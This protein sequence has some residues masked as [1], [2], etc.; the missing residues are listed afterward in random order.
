M[1]IFSKFKRT[2]V[3]DFQRRVQ[4]LYSWVLSFSFYW[5]WPLGI[6]LIK[7]QKIQ[8]KR[9]VSLPLYDRN[10]TG[11]FNWIFAFVWGNFYLLSYAD[12]DWE[13]CKLF[14]TNVEWRNWNPERVHGNPRA[15]NPFTHC[16]HHH[17]HQLLQKVMQKGKG[18][19]IPKEENRDWSKPIFYFHS[20][21]RMILSSLHHENNSRFTK[22]PKR[23][24]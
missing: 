23:G 6:V 21:N 1:G 10:R 3:Q 17:H 20:Y 11:S 22:N 7:T 15:I 2:Q 12:S 24:K 16:H 8:L 9:R 5:S 13:I 18:N 14:W 19:S 4:V